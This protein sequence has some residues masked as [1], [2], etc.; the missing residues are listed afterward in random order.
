MNSSQKSTFEEIKTELEK[1][2][3]ELNHQ[4]V[5]IQRLKLYPKK[6]GTEK[7]NLPL[8]FGTVEGEYLTVKRCGRDEKKTIRQSRAEQ[9]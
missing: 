4:I 7:A 6:D 3:R 1:G 8:N 9:L 2:I 5:N